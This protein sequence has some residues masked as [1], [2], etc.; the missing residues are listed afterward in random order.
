MA[1][2]SPKVY[3]KGRGF[4]EAEKPPAAPKEA[5]N[6]AKKRYHR[7]EKA[8]IKEQK[9]GTT[10]TKIA[11]VALSLL[12]LLMGLLL[13]MFARYVVESSGKSTPKEPTPYTLDPGEHGGALL[14]KSDDGGL[15][16]LRETLFLGDSNT[17][18][19]LHY[20]E[21][22]HLTANSCIGVESMAISGA[23][24]ERRVS[25]EGDSKQ[26]TLAQ[27]VAVL[28]PRRVVITFGTNNIGFTPVDTF[29]ELY[30][31]VVDDIKA[32]YPYADI[33]I[34][35]VPAVAREHDN[36]TITMQEINRYNTRLLQL[37]DEKG[38]WFLNWNEKMQDASTGYM[39]KGYTVDD[40]IHISQFGAET[41]VEYFRTHV[42]ETSDRRPQPLGKIP[43]RLPLKTETQTTDPA[44]GGWNAVPQPPEVTPAS[45]PQEGAPDEPAEPEPLPEE[46]PDPAPEETPDEKKH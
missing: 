46:P 11:M 22:T 24:T 41:M 36:N 1:P 8:L 13:F 15:T 35:A 45:Q 43:N 42:L 37:A 18:R 6:S 27:S 7:T 4:T 32:N 38:V 5:D 23:A 25:F 17:A 12:L 39:K 3:Q 40:G 19:M 14:Q 26:Y 44:T 9:S 20:K 34:G 21:S 2:E 31:K 29:I 28:Q 33:V 16:Y 30:E 10:A